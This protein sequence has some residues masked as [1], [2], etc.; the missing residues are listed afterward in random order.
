VKAELTALGH[1]CEDHDRIRG[2]SSVTSIR[3]IGEG[4]GRQVTVQRCRAELLAHTVGQLVGVV[5]D[6]VVERVVPEVQYP[7]RPRSA[8]NSSNLG[9]RKGW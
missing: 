8:R 5:R 6:D 2:G 1:A 4:I 3:E 7:A 9:R